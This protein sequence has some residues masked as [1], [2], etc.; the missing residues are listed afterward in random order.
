MWE[1]S[2]LNPAIIGGGY[3]GMAAAVELAAQGIPV[4][5]FES[6]RQLGGRARGVLHND[7]QLDNGQHLLLGCYRETLRLIEQVGG[8]IEQDFLRLPLQLDLHGHF[9]LKAPRLPAPLHLLVALLK[10]HGLTWNERMKAVRFMLTLR[11]MNFRLSSDMTVTDL[12]AVHKQDADL[13]FKLWEPLC[14]AALNTPVHK[15][16]AQVLLNVLRDALNRTRADSDMLLPR[17]D[18]TALFPQRAAAFIEQNGGKVYLSCGVDAIVPKDEGIELVS[19]NETHAFSHVICAA[20]ATVAAKLLRPVAGLTDVVAQIEA[21]DHQP[22]YTVYLQYPAHVSLPHPMLGLHRRISQWLFDKGQIADQK[23]LL[24]AVISAEGIHQ[25][26]SQEQ[27][28]QKVIAELSE[29]FGITEQPEWFRVIAEKRAT[30]CCAPDL[31]RPAQQTALSNIL[32]AGDYTAGDYPA[33][34][35]GAVLS[36]IRCARLITGQ[37]RDPAIPVI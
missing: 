13:T 25:E 9:S 17:I 16:S 35:E 26:L 20:P 3:A 34:L 7:T 11:R 5:V 24:A 37:R 2:A 8:D 30:F 22:I 15:A 1:K 19:A 28:A 6:A 4:T 32:L 10:A 36:G 29:E 23:G 27:L 14:I 33:T 18:F 31:Q 21:L 12:L